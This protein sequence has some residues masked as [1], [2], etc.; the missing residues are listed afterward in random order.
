[1]LDGE[2]E[3]MIGRREAALLA[4]DFTP[5]P[6]EPARILRRRSYG[7]PDELPARLLDDDDRV[8]SLKVIATPGHT[9]G[10]I[11]L[12]DTRDRTLIGGDAITT[13]GRTAVSGDLVL[14][15]PFPALSTWDKAYALQS[16]RRLLQAEPARLATGHGPPQDDGTASLTRAISHAA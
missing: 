8:G 9:P 2:L 11:A 13:L 6:G 15:W 10:H 5:A 4:G 3:I 14:R 1:V 12:V 7:H 16:A